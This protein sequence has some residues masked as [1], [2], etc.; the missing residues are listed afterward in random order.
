MQHAFYVQP[1][2]VGV[3]VRQLFI[4]LFFP[5]SNWLMM[6]LNRVVKGLIYITQFSSV[7]CVQY[8]TRLICCFGRRNRNINHLYSHKNISTPIFVA[9][10]YCHHC[11]NLEQYYKYE[12]RA[13]VREAGKQ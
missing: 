13:S 7:V 1:C 8:K 3:N 5:E 11:F 10:C 4:L 2:C 12:Y 6:L 9:L